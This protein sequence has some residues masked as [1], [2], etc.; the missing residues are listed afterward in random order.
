MEGRD[1]EEEW[2]KRRDGREN[3]RMDFPGSHSCCRREEE[4]CASV[5]YTTTCGRM[6][7]ECW[8]PWRESPRAGAGASH[9]PDVDLSSLLGETCL[10]DQET[11]H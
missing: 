5:S 1:G 9:R 8:G 7:I 11:S 10:L 4:L 6:W 3:W 2:G